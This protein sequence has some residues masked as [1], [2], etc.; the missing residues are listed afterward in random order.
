MRG[1]F[2]LAYDSEVRVLHGEEAWQQ[3]TDLVAGAGIIELTSLLPFIFI[4][5]FLLN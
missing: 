5:C 3:G 4:Y 2:V 1:M